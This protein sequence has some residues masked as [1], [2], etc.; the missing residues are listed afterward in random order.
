MSEPAKDTL[1]FIAKA[2][3]MSATAAFFAWVLDRLLPF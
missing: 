1:E 2:L 3:V